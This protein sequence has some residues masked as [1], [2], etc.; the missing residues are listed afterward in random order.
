MARDRRSPRGC[1]AALLAAALALGSAGAAAQTD[2]PNRPIRLITPAAPGGTTDILARIVASGLAEALR[3]PVLVDNRAS[4]SGI[5]AAELT[6]RAAPDGHTLFVV[7]HPHTINAALGAK[8]SYHPV[9]DFTPI[10][11]L[12]TAGL[13]LVVHPATPVKTV[14]DF[15]DW[16]RSLKGAVNF[17]SAGIGSGGHLA[18]ELYNLMTGLKAQ[19]LPYKGSGPALADLVGGH[20]QYAFAGMQAAQGLV[21][22]GRL[23][24]LAVTS[25]KRVPA[26]PELP[27]MAEVLP[28]FEVVGWYGVAGPP[29]MPKPLVARLNAEIVKIIQ[30]P[31]VRERITADGSEPA[32]STPEEFRR[33]MQADL[34]KWTKLAKQ[35]GAKFD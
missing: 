5:L 3:Q 29:K 13:M 17:G 15:L 28:G 14:K 23:R 8:L 4:A 33:F 6:A 30:S 11:Q 20:Y 21:R 35:T 25:P 31:A 22:G 1:A 16:T 7:Y 9:D 10:T 24:A 12:T 2:W 18:G 27:A 26:L 32:T 34:V 19:H